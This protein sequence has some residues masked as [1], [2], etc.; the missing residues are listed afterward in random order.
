MLLGLRSINN[1]D[2]ERKRCKLIILYLFQN[3]KLCYNK[4]ICKN[5]KFRCYSV[6]GQQATEDSSWLIDWALVTFKE[7]INRNK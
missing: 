1:C 7:H 5:L 3:Q 2:K 4:Q 6:E